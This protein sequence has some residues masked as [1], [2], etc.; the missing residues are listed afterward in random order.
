MVILRRSLLLF[1]F[2]FAVKLATSQ[3]LIALLFG[4]KLNSEKVQFGLST[5]LNVTS[6]NYFEGDPRVG[7]N[8][9]LY[10]NFRIHP[11]IWFSPSVMMLYPAGGS[12]LAPYPTGDSTLDV[13]LTD[14]RVKRDLRY[15]SIPL[16]FRGYYYKGF[17]AELGPQVMY[18]SSATDK[19]QHD[20]EAGEL[21]FDRNVEDQFNRLDA[22]LCLGMG[23]KVMRRDGMTFGARFY[24]GFVGLHQD[25]AAANY[26]NTI[27]TFH[28][29]I[30][31]GAKHKEAKK[32]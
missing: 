8:F 32:D 10:F 2:L 5:G 4:D 6:I 27:F 1:L 11:K 25:P 15:L 14:A 7:A 16:M 18:L 20:T 26:R 17:Y 3:V 23:Y 22:G 12:N 30:P 31:V 28:L 13:S 9:G 19:F 24:Y 29:G 21:R